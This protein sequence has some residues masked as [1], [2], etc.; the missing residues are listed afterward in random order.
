MYQLIS[1]FNA[2]IFEDREDLETELKC[3]FVRDIFKKLK[4]T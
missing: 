1:A 3:I 2:S 4:L